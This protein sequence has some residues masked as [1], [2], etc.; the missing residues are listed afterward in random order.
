[1]GTELSHAVTRE[2]A[3]RFFLG[4]DV[5]LSQLGEDL[6]GEMRVDSN[7]VAFGKLN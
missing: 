3:E 4:T 6:G 1:M 7:G 2:G 5:A